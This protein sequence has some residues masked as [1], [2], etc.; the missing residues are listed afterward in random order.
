MIVIT[1]TKN[2]EIRV[3]H[4]SSSSMI[5]WAKMGC[6]LASSVKEFNQFH[7]PPIDI[8]LVIVG[9]IVIPELLISFGEGTEEIPLSELRSYEQGNE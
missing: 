5:K 3:R 1:K 8:S 9:T 4:R 7:N 6:R 2:G